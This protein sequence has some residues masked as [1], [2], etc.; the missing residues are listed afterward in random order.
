MNEIY[1]V[2]TNTQSKPSLFLINDITGEVI[3]TKRKDKKSE[4]LLELIA[5]ALNVANHTGN[6]LLN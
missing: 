5:D 1:K 3:I 6:S 2:A 4:K